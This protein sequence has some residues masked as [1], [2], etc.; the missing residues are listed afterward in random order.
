[1]AEKISYIADLV[2]DQKNTRRH[3][4]RNIGMIAASLH[5]VGAARSIV[6]DENDVVLA[7]HGVIE[8]AGQAGIEKVQVVDADGETIVAVR[9]KGLTEVQKKRLALFDNR[10]AELAEWDLEA[11]AEIVERDR[12]L[13]EGLWQEEEL[14]NLLIGLKAPSD[15]EWT[16]FFNKTGQRGEG[17][18]Y[19]TFV[20]SPSG[21]EEVL[22]ALGNF[23]F[24]RAAGESPR[25]PKP[26]SL[27]D[28][29][30][31]W[32]RLSSDR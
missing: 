24:Q 3:N 26:Q 4:P 15:G 7:G 19:L 22:S 21:Y 17:L 20:L 1:M 29:V 18:K 9:R 13:L 11:L 16:D 27:L 25:H 12:V 28:L 8:A 31:D 6:I 32:Q 14:T 23:G 10:T 30:R 2:P 5:E